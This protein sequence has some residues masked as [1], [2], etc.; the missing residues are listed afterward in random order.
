MGNQLMPPPPKLSTISEL[1]KGTTEDQTPEIKQILP[2]IKGTNYDIDFLN[3]N[4][5]KI[6]CKF[7]YNKNLIPQQFAPLYENEQV[8]LFTTSYKNLIPLEFYLDLG[9][10]IDNINSLSFHP[11]VDLN[12]AAH[13]NNCCSVKDYELSYSLDGINFHKIYSGTYI[14]DHIIGITSANYK[15]WQDEKCEFTPVNLRYFRITILNNYDRNHT[16]NYFAEFNNA[17]LYCIKE[18]LCLDKNNYIHG[19]KN[20]T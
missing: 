3:H 15:V 8:G 18:F 1:S 10:N 20:I 7:N 9:T 2:I 13:W 14:P 5:L 6:K 17:R 12:S 4:G 11:G 16:R 19:C